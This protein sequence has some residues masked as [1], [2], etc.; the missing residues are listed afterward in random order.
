MSPAARAPR[1]SERAG[2]RS[3]FIARRGGGTMA[4]MSPP[5]TLGLAVLVLAAG[6]DR[7]ETAGAAAGFATIEQDELYEHV[8]FLAAPELE[9][10]D[11]PSA[12]LERAARYIAAELAAAGLED[13]PEATQGLLWTY[14]QDQAG[15]GALYQVA[16][17]R[18]RLSVADDGELPFA[19]GTDFV[20]VPGCNGE[21]QGEPVF[22]GFGIDSESEPYNDLK[23]TSWRGK[24]AVILEGEPRHRK[25]FE[26]AVVTDEADLYRKLEVLEERGARGVLVVRRP[27]Q[28]PP[29]RKKGAPAPEPPALSFRHSWAHFKG[30]G[31]PRVRELELPVLE[32]TAEAARRIVGEDVLAL[33]EQMDARGKPLRVECPGREVALSSGTRTGK[34]E[35]HNV[36]GLLKGSDA[37]LA[38]EYV[39]IGAHYDHIGVDPRGRV[40]MGADDNATGTAAVLEV[41]EALAASGTR[42]SVLAVL[43]A[44]EEDGLLGSKAFCAHPPVP[45]DRVVAMINMDMIGVGERDEVIVL[46]LRQNPGLEDV[47][48][49]AQKLQ[50]TRVKKMETGRGYDLYE[51]SDHFSFA[52]QG[53]PAL[54]FYEG[55]PETNNPDY[56]TFDDT[57][58][59]LDF[60]K[61]A[62]TTR[63][64]FNLA[65]LLANDD[66]RP[67]APR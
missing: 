13:V 43:F 26:G 64:V 9:G 49:R 56:H 66:E 8:A 51:R 39:V 31:A 19:L 27:P 4:A 29:W 16:E 46:G 40:G 67:P 22:L 60:D 2:E 41:A 42:R 62:R 34:S 38:G 23:G 30:H 28:A 63:L 25:L 55:Y 3:P 32:I 7:G 35:V 5:R 24:V 54:F 18:C 47:L 10:R 33:G 20:P 6:G 45:L 58:D 57:L 52:S 36:V 59:K 12:G 11:T 48:K 65:W 1:S 44:G 21:A 50:P 15:G 53:V 37:D 14:Q 61:V 17:E